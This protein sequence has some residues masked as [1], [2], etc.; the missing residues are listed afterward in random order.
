MRHLDPTSY[1]VL[2]GTRFFGERLES[3]DVVC[4]RCRAEYEFDDALISERGTTV[5]CTNCGLQFKV[6]PPVGR[7]SPEV[8]RV[9][10]PAERDAEP[11]DYESLAQLQ[12]AISQG[13]VTAAFK[14]VRGDEEPRLLAEIVELQ[15]LLR[16]PRS[17]HPPALS[18]ERAPEPSIGSQGQRIDDAPV[19]SER[20]RSGT[21]L[22]IAVRPDPGSRDAQPPPAFD[23]DEDE[24]KEAVVPATPEPPEELVKTERSGPSSHPK[25]RSALSFSSNEDVPPPS[26]GKDGRASILPR[27]SLRSTLSGSY[28]TAPRSE[29]AS[30][31]GPESLLP[32]EL[33]AAVVVG[34]R[35]RDS[36]PPRIS[37][38]P[39]GPP[40]S[41]SSSEPAPA[42]DPDPAPSASSKIRT[43]SE[44][45]FNEAPESMGGNRTPTPTAMR[46]YQTVDSQPVSARPNLPAPQRARSAML[47]I[48]VVL[49]GGL[50][51]AVSNRHKIGELLG[52]QNS[53]VHESEAGVSEQLDKRLHE[54]EV[55]W[56]RQA[57][58]GKGQGQVA[59]GNLASELSAAGASSSWA[60]VNLKRASGDLV[61]ARLVASKLPA[62][63][64]AAFSLALLDFAESPEDPPWPVIL[65]RLREAAAG[66]RGLY[67]A[68]TAY[69][70][71]L[72]SSGNVRRAQGDFDAFSRLSGA[73]QAPL[74]EE[75]KH[76]VASLST[77]S[78][79]ESDNQSQ[80]RAV[81]GGSKASAPAVAGKP[82][83]AIDVVSVPKSAQKKAPEVEPEPKPT[84]ETP[85]T[86]AP[87][88]AVA[89][90]VSK[91]VQDKV[92]RADSLWRGGDR[93]G[94]LALYRQVVSE[95]GTS[96]FLGQRSAARIRQAEREKSGAK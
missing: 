64:N 9:F 77:E 19:H 74:F 87:S 16:Q 57:F 65:E 42:V 41:A 39:P 72:G 58:F 59:I 30:S 26:S 52:S 94:A 10:N 91:A 1:K 5:R 37:S 36:T 17:D 66:E 92:T 90:K 71:S 89:K 11:T 55:A 51:V 27:T 73:Q 2:K 84:G 29:R 24:D 62:G 20:K 46:A 50:F 40:D 49:G 69:I 86:A 21:T 61:G 43:P 48:V 22:G 18:P 54:A 25:I 83:S 47:V 93:D 6:F 81:A 60:M 82:D 80:P 85:E 28:S 3:M 45:E 4:G 14:L 7:R 70:F 53:V 15:P 34:D 13:E 44:P 38:V 56:M 33:A 75:L 68:R 35:L 95:I 76:F 32:A 96:H 63:G 78:D 31:P 23:E 67:L 88:N 12:R 79:S 8:W